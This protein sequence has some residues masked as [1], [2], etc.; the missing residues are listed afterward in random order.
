MLTATI[1]FHKAAT[2]GLSKPSKMPGWSYGLPA[3]KSCATGSKLAQIPGT[4]CHD[5]YA[6]KGMYQFP[7]VRDAQQRRLDSVSEPG[8]VD[9]MV[10][11][12]GSKKEKYFRWHDSGDLISLDHLSKICQI[13]LRLPQYVF[14][15]PTQEH[16][17]VAQYRK[18][19]GPIPE[20]LTI[21]LSTPKIDGR[22]VTTDLNTSSVHKNAPPQG[23]ECPA[24]H[25]GNTCGDCRACWS[26]E[27][28]NVSYHAH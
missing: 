16:A 6:C 20:N 12:I 18:N 21:R 3:L 19:H 24:P 11:Q 10:A 5:C 1:A 4:V 22:P 17:L 23:H 15:L 28:K 26:K 9:S 8:W 13:A 25:Q 27:V 14:W 2:G 7:V